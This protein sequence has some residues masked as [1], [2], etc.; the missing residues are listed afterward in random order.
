MLVT[1]EY[2]FKDV[3]HITPEWLAQK[4]IRALVLDIDTQ[5]LCLRYRDG[6]ESPLRRSDCR[7]LHRSKKSGSIA[8]HSDYCRRPHGQNGGISQ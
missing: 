2:V 7:D 8:Q 3:T 4:G 5:D 1:P 6:T